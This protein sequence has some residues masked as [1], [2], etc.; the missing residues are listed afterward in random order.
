MVE[1]LQVVG[2]QTLA[3]CFGGY[4]YSPSAAPADNTESWN[5]T[6]W[7]NENTLSTARSSILGD[8]T[9]SLAIAYSGDTPSAVQLGTEEWMGNGIVT[10]T[11]S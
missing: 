2:T 7:T 10:E 4:R 9:Q 1:I 8:G 3:L 6:N 5:G 11:I